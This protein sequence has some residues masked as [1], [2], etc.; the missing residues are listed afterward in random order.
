MPRQIPH[1][2]MIF[3]PV[4]HDCSPKAKEMLLHPDN[5][6]FVSLYK[7]AAGPDEEDQYGLEIGYHVQT[8]PRS[9]VIVEVGKNADLVMPGS[10]IS[11][12]HFSFEIHPESR[13]IMFWDRSRLHSTKISPDGFRVDGN[14]RQV[15][16]LPGT[17]YKISAGAR[18]PPGPSSERSRLDG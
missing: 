15:V 11:Q 2:Q 14:F 10:N 16:L 1:P 12:V 5:K 8:R 9:L 13:Q 17:E 4:P 7:K 18:L 3:H 6:P